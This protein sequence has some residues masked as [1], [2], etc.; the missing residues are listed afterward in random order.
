MNK[1]E[2]KEWLKNRKRYHE[3][4]QNYNDSIAYY[5]DCL[6]SKDKL[7]ELVRVNE[8]RVAV[9][10][11]RKNI[12]PQE[13]ILHLET[14]GRKEAK[15]EIKRYKDLRNSIYAKMYLLDKGFTYLENVNQECLYI[16]E[17]KYIDNMDWNNVEINYNKKYRTENTIGQERIRQIADKGIKDIVNYIDTIPRNNI[18]Y[19]YEFNKKYFEVSIIYEEKY[20]QKITKKLPKSY[21]KNTTN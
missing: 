18:D 11:S 6:S 3:L 1:K 16:V 13:V 19:T 17:C 21:Q 5:Q 14:L 10:T 20:Y 4:I 2:L 9:Q 12:A 8:E 7:I 15:T